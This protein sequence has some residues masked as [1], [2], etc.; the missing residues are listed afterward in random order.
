M[1][2]QLLGVVRVVSETAMIAI[3]VLHEKPA[4]AARVGSR[5]VAFGVDGTAE[6]M[7]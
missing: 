4:H 7:P 1:G 3:R 5:V 2:G 6:V